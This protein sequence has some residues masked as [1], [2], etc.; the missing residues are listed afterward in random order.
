MMGFDLERFA[1]AG[2]NP[3]PCFECFFHNS[4]IDGIYYCGR[5]SG[6]YEVGNTTDKPPVEINRCHTARRRKPQ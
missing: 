2:D 3:L 6:P 4:A 5:F 1:R